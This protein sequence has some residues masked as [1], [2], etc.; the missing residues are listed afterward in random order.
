MPTGLNDL[1]PHCNFQE[2]AEVFGNFP[3]LLKK[4]K[5]QTNKK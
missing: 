1:Q 4:K 2:K 3:D 5:K